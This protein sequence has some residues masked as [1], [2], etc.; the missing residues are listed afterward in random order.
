MDKNLDSVIRLKLE[1]TKKALEKNRFNVYIA[2]NSKEACDIAQSLMKD[3]ALVAS[4][5]SRSLEECGMGEIL[6][7]GKYEYLDREKATDMTELFRKSFFADYYLSSSNAI[8]ENGE[9]FN[10]DG[11]ANRVACICYGPSNVI[12]IAGHNKI[13]K[14]IDEA[15]KRVKNIAAPANVKRLSCNTYCAQTGRCMGADGA[16]T[17]GCDG[18]GRICSSYVVNAFQRNQGRISVILVNEELGY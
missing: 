4:G 7:S 6:R 18:C 16:M 13:V 15:A 5:G 3:G 2:D 14:D 10:V 9:L 1:R 11:N 8:T 17:D 12:I